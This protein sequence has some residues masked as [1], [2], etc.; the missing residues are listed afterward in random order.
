MRTEQNTECRLSPPDSALTL[1]VFLKK[2][3]ERPVLQ[4]HPWIFSGAIERAEGDSEASTVVD[5]LDSEGRWLARGLHNPRSQ[6]RVRLLTW[7]QEPLDQSFFTRRIA[8]AAA[9]RARYLSPVT[10]AYRLVNGEGDFLP[11]LVVDRYAG[12]LIC[13]FLT[14]GM[15]S[16]KGIVVESLSKVFPAETI[17]E[18]SEGSVREEE[19][20]SPAVGVVQGEEP[21]ARI[22]IE[23]NGAKFL[24]DVKAG[25]KTGF[26][27]DQRE[28]RLLLSSL[29]RDK[30]ILNCFAYTGGFTLLALKGGA[31]EV[32]SVESSR[33]AL[34]LAEQSLHLNG[35]SSPEARWVKADAFS[36]LKVCRAEFDIVVLDPPSL[37]PRRA[38]VEAAAG[39]YKFLN[40]HAL[41][42]LKPAGLLLTFCCSQHVTSDLFQ[43][44]VFGAAVDAR[45]KVQ[46]IKRL[47]H[48]IDHPVSL[49]HPEGEY[50]KGLL[51]RV[52]E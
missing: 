4:G 13:Q 38:D 37:A 21:P 19:G 12:F 24:V 26:F 14:A 10:N 5:V 1:R 15:D 29:A 3:R 52:L 30:V 49:H 36:Y 6:I 20:L 44:I 41:R 22:E 23:E 40:L 27:L 2:G 9:L 48:A 16:L 39:G 43:K 35:L 7:T 18:R 28:H 34:E 32:V 31:R 11:G 25:Q 17:Y 47:G 8:H 45:R 50:L 51:L 33:P 42:I 46:V